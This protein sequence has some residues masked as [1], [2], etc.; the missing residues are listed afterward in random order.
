MFRSFRFVLLGAAGLFAAVFLAGLPVNRGVTESPALKALVTAVGSSLAFEPRL[1]GGFEPPLDGPLRGSDTDVELSPDV[2]IAIAE[3]EKR[4]LADPSVDTLSL[5]GVAL[6]VHGDI[7]RAI[8]TLE[9]AAAEAKRA[10]VWSDLSAAYLVKAN[11]QPARRV[12]YLARALEAAVR[13][14]R[15]SSSNEARFN[16]ALAMNGLA[17]LVGTADP[18]GDYVRG[19]RDP[20]WIERAASLKQQAPRFEDARD[21]WP[22][23]KLALRAALDQRQD[24]AVLETVRRFPEA[25]FEMLDQELL[26]EWANGNPTALDSAHRLAEAFLSGTGD[27]GPLEA[28]FAIRKSGRALAAAHIAYAAALKA[29]AADEYARAR[30][31]LGTALAAFRSA[32]SPYEESAQAQFASIDFNERRLEDALARVDALIS[33]AERLGHLTVRARALSLRG[34]ILSKQWRLN[35]ALAALRAAASQF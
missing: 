14:L 21:E 5:L 32:Q 28:V 7:D 13:S 18:W 27:R 3:I 12:E 8:A 15:L 20:R 23:R 11:R 2:R 29:I 10:S 35:E 19:E 24:D 33:H 17:P 22:S 31:H 4:A 6:L 16:Y 9:D 26:V 1:T 30:T 34:L 25:S